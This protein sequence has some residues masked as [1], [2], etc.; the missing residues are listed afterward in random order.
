MI[1]CSPLFLVLLCGISQHWQESDSKSSL[2]GGSGMVSLCYACSSE[3]A[4]NKA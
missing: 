2:V 3:S 1:L 4:E